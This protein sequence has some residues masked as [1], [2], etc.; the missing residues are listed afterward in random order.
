MTSKTSLSLYVIFYSNENICQDYSISCKDPECTPDIVFFIQM[1][2]LLSTKSENSLIEILSNHASLGNTKNTYL[3]KAKALQGQDLVIRH[4]N[5]TTLTVRSPDKRNHPVPDVFLIV[6]ISLQTLFQHQF[7][8]TD[9]F[10]DNRN[11]QQHDH[12]RND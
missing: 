5:L 4:N 1:I 11:I 12:K 6:C 3:I 10:A 7:L 8:I 2:I 9:P